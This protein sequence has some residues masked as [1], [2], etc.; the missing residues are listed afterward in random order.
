VLADEAIAIV[1]SANF[2]M[3]SMFLNYEVA[4]SLTGAGEIARVARWFDD[5]FQSCEIGAPRAAWLRARIETTARL[6]AP[7]V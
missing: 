5:T 6:V 3:R 7:L 4:T 2:D 1:G